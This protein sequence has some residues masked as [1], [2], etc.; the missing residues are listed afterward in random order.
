MTLNIKYKS[1][2]YQVLIDDADAIVLNYHMRLVKQHKNKLRVRILK[3]ENGKIIF[4]EYLHR[5]L[6]DVKDK[7]IQVDHKDG[8]PLNNMRSNL[9]LATNSQ[10]NSYRSIDSRNSSGYKGVYYDKERNK[11][12][13]EIKA[14]GKKKF[15]GRF[16]TKE[17]AALAYNKMAIL[18]HKEFAILNTVTQ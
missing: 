2:I 7:N 14:D 18:L 6:L 9:R 3:R 1:K 8:N 15:I 13:A 17:E 5:F 11:W 16:E 10:N 12:I 4:D